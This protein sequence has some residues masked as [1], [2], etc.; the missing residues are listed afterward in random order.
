[1]S[2]A[3]STEAL[4]AEIAERKVEVRT[5]DR[6]RA[7]AQGELRRL[8]A[9][10]AALEDASPVAASNATGSGTPVPATAA[11][12]V[13][14]FRKNVPQER[15]RYRAQPTAFLPELAVLASASVVTTVIDCFLIMLRLTV[16]TQARTRDS[17]TAGNG[18]GS[19][20]FFAVFQ[21]LAPWQLVAR[22]IDGVLDRR[23]D[24]V[25]YCPVFCKSAS[26]S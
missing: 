12:K 25:L 7:V 24:L 3:E 15:L 8:E 19:V 14:L 13:A 11:E 5:L 6:Q 17:L 9:E 26:H 18:D 1:M 4:R 21:A 20:T 10:L 2:N 16:D 23:I 22:A